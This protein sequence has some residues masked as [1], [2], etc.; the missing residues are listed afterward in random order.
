MKEL[1]QSQYWATPIDRVHLLLS[2]DPYQIY[3]RQ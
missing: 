3:D 1:F 2:V